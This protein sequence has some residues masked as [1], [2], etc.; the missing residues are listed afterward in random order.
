MS[1]NIPGDFD[2]DGDVDLQ[3]TLAALKHYGEGGKQMP[4]RAMTVLMRDVVLPFSPEEAHGWLL[5]WALPRVNGWLKREVGK[6][7]KFHDF[8][9]FRSKYRLDEIGTPDAYGEGFGGHTGDA[10]FLNKVMAVE[11]GRHNLP[12]YKNIIQILGGGGIGGSKSSM[13]SFANFTNIMVGDWVVRSALD[14]AAPSCL[15][16][17]SVA[18]CST[19]NIAP[20]GHEIGHSLNIPDG[21]TPSV[22]HNADANLTM[23][24]DKPMTDEQKAALLDPRYAVWLQ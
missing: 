12:K 11:M 22:I 21:M 1:D 4:Y 9:V 17:Y 20:L 24:G 14:V 15:A 5:G 8:G 19:P 3:D 23:W 18:E 6:G 16:T 7:L 2:G 13:D 10:N